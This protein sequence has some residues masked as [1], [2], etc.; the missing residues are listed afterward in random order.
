MDFA[1]YLEMEW[2]VGFVARSERDL[3]QHFAFDVRT[4]LAG[5]CVAAFGLELLVAERSDGN[6]HGLVDIHHCPSP[7]AL[8]IFEADDTASGQS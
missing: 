2:E 6:A 7:M 3:E 8:H 4:Q 5:N 1:G